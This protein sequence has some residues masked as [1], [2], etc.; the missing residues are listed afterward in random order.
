MFTGCVFH[1]FGGP[2]AALDI[3]GH[4]ADEGRAAAF[5]GKFL[6]VID[7]AITHFVIAR[8]DNHGDIAGKNR[9]RRRGCNIGGHTFPVDDH[10]AG[11]ANLFPIVQFF[12]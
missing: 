7:G 9:T 11:G 2:V 8:H 10:R 6:A 4:F 1:A 3:G 5:V 12:L